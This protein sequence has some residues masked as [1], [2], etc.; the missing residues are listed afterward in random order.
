M[1]KPRAAPRQQRSRETYE[2]VLDVAAEI[3]TEFG[4]TGTTT[5]KVAEA[6]GISIGTLYHYIP[7]K[8]ALLYSLTER[9]LT[10]GVDSV[11]SVFS[12]LREESSGLEES[13]RVI[14]SLVIEMHLEERHLHHLLYDSAPRSEE[15]QK[16]LREADAAMSDEVA[17]HLER[18]GVAGE[19][20]RLM[21]SLLVTGIEAQVHRATLAP[22][23]P[24][25]PEVLTDVLTKL[26]TKALTES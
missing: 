7:D 22:I 19:H 24:V 1:A 23:E 3:F 11:V 14:I 10:S 9:H 5:N 20:R 8:D 15:L 25:S 6:A 4:Y 18:L 21:A 17:W 12:R 2:R 26:W 13:L 16:R